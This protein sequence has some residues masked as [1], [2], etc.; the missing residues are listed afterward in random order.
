MFTIVRLLMC[1]SLGVIAGCS[2][3]PADGPTTGAFED[4]PT[5]L[6]VVEADM[7]IIARLGKSAPR[8][9]G[10]VFP[11]DGAGANLGIE[12]GDKVTISVYENLT[13][14]PI[15][16]LFN[17]NEVPS[18]VV[19]RK[20]TIYVPFV[21]VIRVAGQ[22]SENVAERIRRRL[23]QKTF[24][25]AV[26]VT[27]EKQFSNAVSVV[28]DATEGGLTVL[29][30]GAER[31]MDAIAQSGGISA[32]AHEIE[33]E[34]TRGQRTAMM[35]FTAILKNPRHNVRLVPGDLLAVMHRPRT[36]VASGANRRGGVIPFSEG[37][38]SLMEGIALAGGL[39]DN[40]A[41][42]SGIF[43]LRYEPRE[44]VVNLYGS[45]P[46]AGP[47]VPVIYRFNFRDP[48]QMFLARRFM[49]RHQDILY[50]SNSTSVQIQKFLDLFRTTFTSGTSIATTA[51]GF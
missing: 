36:F 47:D 23:G 25:P 34:L 18:Q 19:S 33:V 41:N 20:G 50:V 3:L 49:M 16:S 13:S 44:F 17:R 39:L 29:S 31:L 10:D 43:I 14:D 27:V 7:E 28:G 35:P 1:M 24:D 15:A 32:P 6:L 45:A 40:R 4:A 26:L 37:R 42:P 46:V 8:G 11:V 12:V 9:P 48:A 22:T 30:P 51:G 21:G 2:S 38:T 5:P